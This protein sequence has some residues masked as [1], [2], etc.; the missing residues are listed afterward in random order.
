MKEGGGEYLVPRSRSDT[1]CPLIIIS[2]VYT[3]NTAAGISQVKKKKSANKTLL[4]FQN[5]KKIKNEI[6]SLARGEE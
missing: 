5:S 2:T 1:E 3:V 6:P 4:I